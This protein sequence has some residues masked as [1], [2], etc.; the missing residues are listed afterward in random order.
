MIHPNFLED[1]RGGKSQKYIPS[2]LECP[3]WT[4]GVMGFVLGVL[5][6][7]ICFAYILGLPK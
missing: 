6:S 5:S 1:L 7:S 3:Q 2:C 4:Y